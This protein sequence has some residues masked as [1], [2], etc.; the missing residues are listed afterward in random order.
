MSANWDVVP[1]KTTQQ[2]T[3]TLKQY[4]DEH[5]AEIFFLYD[6]DTE[7]FEAW[8]EDNDG[9]TQIGDPNITQNQQQCVNKLIPDWDDIKDNTYACFLAPTQRFER[10][11]E[12][13]T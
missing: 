10:L 12:L 2:N 11:E 4:D 8:V 5:N 13:L 3:L 6:N 9:V 7:K 1:Y